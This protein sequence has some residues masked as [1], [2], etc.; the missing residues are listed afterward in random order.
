MLCALV[1]WVVILLVKLNVTFL[2]NFVCQFICSLCKKGWSNWPKVA[3][4]PTLKNAFLSVESFAQYLIIIMQR[5]MLCNSHHKREVGKRA[6]SFI[7]NFDLFLDSRRSAEKFRSSEI[8]GI[9]F[10]CWV[11]NKLESVKN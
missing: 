6:F 1:K 4:L 8:C 5:F 10:R 11:I 3:W 2:T 9:S 7:W